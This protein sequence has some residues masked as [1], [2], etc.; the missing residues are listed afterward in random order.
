MTW[1]DRFDMIVTH[2]WEAW[3]SNGE[4]LDDDMREQWM[5][6]VQ[7]VATSAWVNDM[8][9]ARWLAATLRVLRHTPKI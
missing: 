9:D 7:D 3:T 5:K 1:D 4:G 6:T 2:A 8:T